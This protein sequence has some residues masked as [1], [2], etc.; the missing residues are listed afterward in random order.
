MSHGYDGIISSIASIVSSKDISNTL[1][2]SS[3]SPFSDSLA[4]T[5]TSHCENANQL[6][7]NYS[8]R[9]VITES[10]GK[11]SCIV[12]VIASEAS[13]TPSDIESEAI[14]KETHVPVHKRQLIREK[15]IFRVDSLLLYST[16]QSSLNKYDD[17]LRRNPLACLATLLDAIR[18]HESITSEKTSELKDRMVESSDEVDSIH[19]APLRSDMTIDKREPLHLESSETIQSADQDFAV[20]ESDDIMY[21]ERIRQLINEDSDRQEKAQPGNQELFVKS[22]REVS[23]VIIRAA[24]SNGSGLENTTLRC[25]VL[26]N[27]SSS[28]EY[29]YIGQIF[30]EVSSVLGD[31]LICPSQPLYSPLET[32]KHR[33]RKW[34][35]RI[36]ISQKYQ[37]DEYPVNLLSSWLIGGTIRGDTIVVDVS[38]DRLADVT[39][40]SFQH[41]IKATFPS[42]IW[43]WIS[44]NAT[45]PYEK[46]GAGG[47]AQDLYRLPSIYSPKIWTIHELITKKPMSI[48]REIISRRTPTDSVKITKTF[49]NIRELLE[50]PPLSV[51]AIPE[52]WWSSSASTS[53]PTEGPAAA[54]TRK[55]ASHMIVELTMPTCRDYHSAS[56]FQRSY[57]CPN[58]A[59]EQAYPE[60]IPDIDLS[61]IQSKY[62]FHINVEDIEQ[63]FALSCLHRI[64]SSAVRYL[65]GHDIES[66]DNVNMTESFKNIHMVSFNIE[67]FKPSAPSM[68]Y[69]NQ[70]AYVG[71]HMLPPCIEGPLTAYIQARDQEDNQTDSDTIADIKIST[72]VRE[73]FHPQSK[74]WLSSMSEESPDDPLQVRI[75]I[76]NVTKYRHKNEI[77]NYIRP[78]IFSPVLADQ[79]RTLVAS[80]LR[81]MHATSPTSSLSWLDAGC[82]NG[83]FL[84][85]CLTNEASIESIKHVYGLDINSNR[86]KELKRSFENMISNNLLSRF[87]QSINIRE[88]SLLDVSHCMKYSN[89]IDIV[90][91]IE[92]IEHLPSIKVA[93]IAVINILQYIRPKVCLVSTPNIEVN[94][95]IYEEFK[96]QCK[97]YGYQPEDS[98]DIDDEEIDGDEYLTGPNRLRERDHKFELTRKEYHEFVDRCLLAISQISSI[99]YDV[100]F[101]ELGCRLSG[102]T[103]AGGATQVAV[104]V[105]TDAPS[106]DES[107][108]WCWSQD[109]SS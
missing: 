49:C 22:S 86:L 68:I 76:L 32:A 108:H 53:L 72:T 44:H 19:L 16:I 50:D 42:Q 71:V 21:I 78:R 98:E 37:R 94:P 13:L 6:S 9:K 2:L 90:S 64:E 10:I 101:V 26:I 39:V 52:G 35:N 15:M 57:I 34:G 81:S 103:G 46:E 80:I 61:E 8:S 95:L 55:K 38:Y 73:L 99:N 23:I 43:P 66:I 1:S 69:S 74:Y 96:R 109:K 25:P 60:A 7:K 77:F 12:D 54:G 14:D 91:C 48:L 93:E 79:R 45:T 89:K 33:N 102:L 104:F 28:K 83:S 30:N 107:F 87:V 40:S 11:D 67:I 27:T 59:T 62:K 31:S 106:V 65:S 4:S 51:D 5:S 70:S 20:V 29:P 100:T 24:P 82:G 85:G 84:I 63:D 41:I 17:R 97:L 3:F 18:R 58:V 92:V 56:S 75:F 47:I 36:F 88:G 105:K